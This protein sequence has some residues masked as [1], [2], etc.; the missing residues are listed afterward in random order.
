VTANLT[1]RNDATGDH[2]VVVD[3]FQ[4]AVKNSGWS[5]AAWTSDATSG[6]DS[7]DPNKPYTHAYNFG[8]AASPGINGVT[9]TGRAGAN[10]SVGGSFAMAGLPNVFPNDGN[11]L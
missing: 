5:Y 10:P 3:D 2:T 7:T 1:L 4:I 11:N 8:S 9:F 6:V